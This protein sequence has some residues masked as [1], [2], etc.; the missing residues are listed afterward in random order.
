MRIVLNRW[1]NSCRRGVKRVFEIRVVGSRSGAHIRTRQQQGVAIKGVRKKN[2]ETPRLP[3]EHF[4]KMRILCHS[5]LTVS[6]EVANESSH[7]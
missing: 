2:L 5:L 6:M 4:S 1:S 3:L 7:F